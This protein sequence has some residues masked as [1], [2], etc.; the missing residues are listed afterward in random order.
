MSF[1]RVAVALPVF[2]RAA[3]AP[4]FTLLGFCALAAC[5]DDPAPGATT[6][7]DEDAEVEPD[8]GDAGS[9]PDA[10]DP[11]DAA[12]NTDSSDLSQ[13][14]GDVLDFDV[15]NGIG[16]PF[17]AAIVGNRVHMVYT[18][19]SGGGSL[20][21]PTSQGLAYVTFET[22]GDP[23]AATDIVN[24]GI[25]TYAKTRDPALV[26]RGSELD[27][28]YTSNEEDS[29]ELYYKDLDANSTPVRQTTNMRNEYHTVAAASGGSVGV[30]YSE[31][32]PAL[33]MP[34]AVALITSPGQPPIQLV[35]EAKGLHAAQLSFAEVGAEGNKHG[36]VGFVSD[37]EGA[38]GI[39]LQGVAADGQ[40][41]GELVTLSKEV[42]GASNIDIASGKVGGA[43]IYTEAPGEEKV[44]HQLRFRELTAG[45]QASS[46]VRNLTSANQNLR[47]VALTS[48]SAGYVIAY[49]RLGGAPDAATTVFL[50]FV[51]AQGNFSGTRLV[52]KASVGGSGIEVLVANDGRL[53]VIWADTMQG[54]N[55]TTNKPE[56]LLKVH[57]ARL[58]CVVT[59][60]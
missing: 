33:S 53:V 47:D 56:T 26:A 38:S 3:R 46:I 20:A 35:T 60:P 8:A 24:V 17:T 29:Y 42:G 58:T 40:P 9:E 16:R 32:P 15:A 27:L 23:S 51:D 14:E 50:M 37:L 48:Y 55:P 52:Q 6:D 28:F 4:L 45:G 21:K 41:A 12:V 43:V 30:V 7:P 1:Q 2:A 10:S 19:P 39:F 25:D 54:T 22:T 5:G 59:K 49:R 57:A 31:E 44:I 36:V 18:V 13:C 34:G 11:E